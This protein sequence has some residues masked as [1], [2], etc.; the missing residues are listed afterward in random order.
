[1]AL[2]RL[3][4]VVEALRRGE[5]VEPFGP[6]G[7]MASPWSYWLVRWPV[8]RERPVL[9]AFEAWVVEQAHR[10]QQALGGTPGIAGSA[11]D[12]SAFAPPAPSRPRARRLRQN[13]P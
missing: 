9:A 2:A 12:T 3:A 4:L 7:R 13:E 10:T 1:V 8:R 5:L 6:A 11:V